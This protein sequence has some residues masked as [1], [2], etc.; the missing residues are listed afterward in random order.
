MEIKVGQKCKLVP[1]ERGHKGKDG[2]SCMRTIKIGKIEKIT[3]RYI[4]I[5]TKMYRVTH[6]I[7][8]MISP[9]EYNLFIWSGKEW[10]LVSVPKGIRNFNQLGWC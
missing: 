4:T 7:A 9:W 2:A 1:T 8:D 10:E 5:K 6:S 3:D